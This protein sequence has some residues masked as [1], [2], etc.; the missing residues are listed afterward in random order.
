MRI[1]S[2]AA[3]ISAESVKAFYEHRASSY[4]G[5]NLN[6]ITMLHDKNPTLSEER[7]KSEIAKLLP[8]LRIAEDSCVLDLACGAGRWLPVLP[9]FAT[10]RGI[11]FSSGLIE[12]ARS[13][14]TRANAEFFTGSVLDA[15]NI[16]VDEKGSFNRIM[17]IGSLMYINDD[18]VI[19]LFRMLPEMMTKEGA[20]ICVKASIG[21]DD[22]LTL[23]DFY[24]EELQ[25]D[26]N[27]IYRTRD[28]Y[29]KLFADALMPSGFI[30]TDE[31]FMFDDSHLNNRK[32]TAQYYFI[33]ER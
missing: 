9:E 16:L 27:A 6:N 8:K 33:L 18:D 13:N 30:V 15:D 5:E 24:S 20:L 19:S 7:N 21:I 28:E 14:N 32:E 22:R 25:S 1:K 29:M 10:Y 3:N 11:D 17:M 26:Y 23:K 4:T 12:I 31:G 2:S